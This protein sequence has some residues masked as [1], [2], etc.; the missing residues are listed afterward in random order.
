MTPRTQRLVRELL[1]LYAKYGP[2]EF[3]HALEAL[4]TGAATDLLFSA[5]EQVAKVGLPPSSSSDGTLRGAKKA[6]PRDRFD[7]FQFHL[8]MDRKNHAHGELHGFLEQ[9]AERKVLGN[10][11][12]L[13]EFA[14]FLDIPTGVK[15]ERY[16]IARKIGEQLLPQSETSLR[17]K[18]QI[19]H[20]MSVEQSTL[21]SWADIIVKR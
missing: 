11:R 9:I 7:D 4:R 2:A 16:A 13:R 14:A 20:E 10:P 5:V 12:T 18:V 3:S 17:E 15:I 6:S 8:A 1:G 21:Q 19:A